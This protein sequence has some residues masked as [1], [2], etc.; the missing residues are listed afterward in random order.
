[1]KDLKKDYKEDYYWFG[2]SFNEYVSFRK[3]IYVVNRILAIILVAGFLLVA[4]L[5]LQG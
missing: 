2:G 3:L 5:L 1:M 4:R